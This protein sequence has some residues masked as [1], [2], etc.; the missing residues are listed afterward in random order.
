MFSLL[1]FVFVSILL[2]NFVAKRS[3]ADS[4]TF[5]VDESYTQA[6]N[7]SHVI[8]KDVITEK[9]EEKLLDMFQTFMNHATSRGIK[10]ILA[11]GTLLG[12]ARHGRRMPWD[13]DVDLM[14]QDTDV[15]DLVKGLPNATSKITS[16][17]CHEPERCNFLPQ[18]SNS[19]S[20]Q[21]DKII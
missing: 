20:T 7:E 11:F 1:G 18:I 10:P 2:I 5:T 9:E 15:F 16:R 19:K 8:L 6:M 12:H 13:D 17:W 14:I 21:Y 4:N 3:A